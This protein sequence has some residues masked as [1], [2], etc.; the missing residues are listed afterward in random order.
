LKPRVLVTGANGFIGGFV[1]RSLAAAGYQVRAA[2]RRPGPD[3]GPWDEQ[4]VV[5]EIESGTDWS[6]AL[7]DVD[8]VVHTAARVHVM[9]EGVANTDAYLETNVMGTRGLATA[10]SASGVKRLVFIS[11]VKVNG[12]EA[13][14][15]AYNAEDLPTPQ[16]PYG[17]SKWQAELHLARAC[18]GGSM[19]FAIVRPPLVYGPG[20]RANFL[21]L[22]RW[23]NHGYPLPFA[24]IRNQRSLVSAWNLADL[25]VNLV[26]NPAAA[27]KT[28]MVS[29]GEDIS[30]AELVRRLARAMGRPSRV[31]PVP[32]GM[33]RWAGRLAG[34]RAEVDRLCGSLRVDVTQ[35]F[36]ALQWRPPLDLDTGLRKTAEWYVSSR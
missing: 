5:G 14:D 10:A 35:T 6:E 16:D 11:S 19:Q 17:V 24:A 1:C 12:E 23:V 36:S 7:V 13:A 28:W 18:A 33:L 31:F 22:M 8:H 9:Q 34:R 25:V 21:R 20:V 32:E 4:A 29:D 15:H 26:G 27:N 30:T 2:L 3:T